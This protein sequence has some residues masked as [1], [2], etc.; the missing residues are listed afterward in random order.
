MEEDH[1]KETEEDLV[2]ACQ[3]DDLGW[4]LVK[5]IEPDGSQQLVR[6]LAF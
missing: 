3:D 4:N 5:K 6:D 1:G 2:R